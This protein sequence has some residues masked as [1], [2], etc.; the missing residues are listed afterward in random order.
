[1]DTELDIYIMFPSRPTH[2]WQV[3]TKLNHHQIFITA[4]MVS[5]MRNR[6]PCHTITIMEYDTL[7]F[8]T[9]IHSFAI[10]GKQVQ[11]YLNNVFSSPQFHYLSF[12]WNRLVTEETKL[13]DFTQVSI[14]SLDEFLKGIL[15]IKSRHLKLLCLTFTA[16]TTLFLTPF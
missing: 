4:F 8:F 12:S 13:S 16:S 10:Q 6:S 9:G 11:V 14:A 7:L 5:S 3:N 1:M 15:R 2:C